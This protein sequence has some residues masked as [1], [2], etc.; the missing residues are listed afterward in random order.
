[1]LLL[2]FDIKNIFKSLLECIIYPN[3]RERVNPFHSHVCMGKNAVVYHL[4]I[5]ML[6]LFQ[7]TYTIN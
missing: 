2:W 4:L 7:N 6:G 3:G 1:M 5:V